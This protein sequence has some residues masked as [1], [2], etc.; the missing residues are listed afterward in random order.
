MALEIFAGAFL[1]AS[2]HVLFDRLASSE[3]WTFIGGQKVSE[4]LLL[5]LGMKLLVVDKVLDHAEVKQ[6]TDERVKRWLVRVKNAVYDAED[7]L[8]EITTEALRRKM[9]AADSQ[10]GPTH[11]LNSFSTWFKAPLA[12][13]QSM[14]SKVKKIIGKLEVLA[15]AI[16]VLA[17]KGDEEQGKIN[18]RVT[19]EINKI[20]NCKNFRSLMLALIPIMVHKLKLL[21]NYVAIQFLRGIVFQM[22]STFASLVTLLIRRTVPIQ[23][24]ERWALYSSHSTNGDRPSAVLMKV[25]VHQYITRLHLLGVP[26]T[27]GCGDALFCLNKRITYQRS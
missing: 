15:Q 18:H 3:V 2:L 13:H 4:E 25:V 9:E 5:E 8:D 10:T 22:P 27:K 12:D 7:L 21:H 14:E 19:E 11:V 1:S 16:D 6:F 24:R 20:S 17:L 23:E 26:V